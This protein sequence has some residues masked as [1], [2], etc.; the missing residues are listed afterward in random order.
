MPTA[1]SQ[2][3]EVFKSRGGI[4]RTREALEA[5]IHPRTLYAMRNAGQLEQVARGVYR[6]AE[7]P[8]LSNPDL[9]AVGKRV[10]QGVICLIS[11]LA[12]HE[13]TTQIPHVVHLAMPRKARTPRLAHPPLQVYWFS[14]D[15]YK[16]GVE[17]HNLEGTEVRIYDPEKTLAD[18]FK[19]RNKIG[20]DVAIEALRIYRRRRGARLQRVLEYARICRV[21]AVIR[22]YLEASA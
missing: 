8:P 6:L 16:A 4:L 2:A 1:S 21:E 18:C 12:F 5:G 7:L 22:P 9:A 14:A 20:L 17:T 15:A 10:P 11:A 3:H 19:Y 13:L